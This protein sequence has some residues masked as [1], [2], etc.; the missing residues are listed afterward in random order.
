MNDLLG[1][2]ELQRR[3][4]NELQSDLRRFLSLA[5]ER[6]L[7]RENTLWLLSFSGCAV[8]AIARLE[9]TPRVSPVAA[10]QY[11]M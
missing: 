1:V 2:A 6:G 9:T 5:H 8:A 7:S 11:R 10:V 4:P 3:Y